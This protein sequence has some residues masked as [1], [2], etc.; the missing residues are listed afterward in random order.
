ME[1]FRLTNESLIC[2]TP[3]MKVCR[4]DYENSEG[5]LVMSHM[6][7]RSRPS[8]AVIVRNE[9]GKIALIRQFR[10]TT[11]QYY[12]EIPAGVLEE[13]ETE[14]QA[15][16]RETQEETGLLIRNINVFVKGPSLLDPSKGDENFGVAMADV[17]GMGSQALDESEQ[18]DAKIFWVPENT[19]LSSVREQILMGEKFFGELFMSGHSLY[20]L[21]AYM[22]WRQNNK[23]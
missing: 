4:V 18:I 2:E 10:S 8:V 7:V 3:R 13:G 22:L 17:Y 19:V 5:K 1:D 23:D 6:I 12:Y 14:E 9:G 20:A 16:R 21:M 11:G 15:A